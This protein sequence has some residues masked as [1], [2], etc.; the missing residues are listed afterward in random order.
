MKHSCFGNFPKDK[1][2]KK[3]AAPEPE[4]LEIHAKSVA[5]SGGHETMKKKTGTG[6]MPYSKQAPK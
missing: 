2:P 3:A 5:I 4:P 6:G 1:M